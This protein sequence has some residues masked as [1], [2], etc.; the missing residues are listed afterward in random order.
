MFFIFSVAEFVLRK[1]AEFKSRLDA[2]VP[3]NTIKG[4]FEAHITLDCTEQAIEKLKTACE[5]TH[6]IHSDND[7][8]LQLVISS[9]YHG[10]Y[11]SI[12]KQIEEEVY[13]HFADFQIR[14]IQI[15]SLVSNE[16]VPRTYIDKKLFWNKTNYFQFH[17]SVPLE[18][19]RHGEKFKKLINTCQS[20]YRLNLDL[21]RHRFKQID[22][23]NLQYISIV[24]F[25]NV[26][27]EKAFEINDEIIKY[28]AEHN[29]PSTTI[30]HAFVVYDR[31]IDANND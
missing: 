4:T 22:G 18:K 21:S 7:K 16:G 26:G 8:S 14:R 13:Q 24:C 5:N 9:S 10:E 31:C 11:P 6:F 19:D 25:L 3:T 20:K 17:Y 1:S 27:Q 30:K 28:S 29:F 23:N 12:V 15:E 2:L